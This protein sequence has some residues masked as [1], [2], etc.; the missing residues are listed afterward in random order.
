MNHGFIYLKAAYCSLLVQMIK[1]ENA[2]PL[3]TPQND[4]PHGR[5]KLPI[6]NIPDNTGALPV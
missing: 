6:E 3:A 2:I 4:L 1:S 5:N